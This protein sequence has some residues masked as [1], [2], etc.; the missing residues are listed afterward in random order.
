[1]FYLDTWPFSPPVLVVLSPIGMRQMTQE[2]PLL[3]KHKG[4]RHF[5][6]PLSGKHDLVTMEGQMW[7]TWRTRFNPGFSANHL[8]TLVPAILEDVSIFYGILQGH[9]EK[10]DLFSLEE[11][12]LSVTLDVIGRVTLS[13]FKYRGQG[14]E[15]C[16]F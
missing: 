4:Q 15:K 3:P 5:L 8:M 9:A 7:K 1:M 12:T 14:H 2:N 6:R 16:G 11:A 13:V 10:G